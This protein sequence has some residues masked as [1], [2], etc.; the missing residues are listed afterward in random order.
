[1]IS[2]HD[3]N[4]MSDRAREAERLNGILD[5]DCQNHSEEITGQLIAD[6]R[7]LISEVIRL[8]NNI[9]AAKNIISNEKKI[10]RA[11]NWRISVYP[12]II[13]ALEFE[14]DKDE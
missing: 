12:A 2:D 7:A 8:Q 1:M 11:N 10:M 5:S 3:L 13:H 6:T 9:I 14:E 4:Q